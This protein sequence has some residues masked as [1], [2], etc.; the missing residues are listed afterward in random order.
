MNNLKG[1]F[2][3]IEP[4]SQ[5]IDFKL[6]LSQL[7]NQDEVDIFDIQDLLNFDIDKLKEI[8]KKCKSF[9]EHFEN[10]KRGETDQLFKF[11]T[12]KYKVICGYKLKHLFII[13]LLFYL[14]LYLGYC[15]T[16]EKCSNFDLQFG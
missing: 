6:I 1:C 13:Y 3:D 5:A 8:K 2:D 16:R 15:I 9:L 10:L 4:H 11:F 14:F 12:E 7:K